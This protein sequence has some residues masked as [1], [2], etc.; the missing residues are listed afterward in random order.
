M[1]R[2]YTIKIHQ[3]SK[4]FKETRALSNINLEFE[5]GNIY[6]IVGRNGS[7]KTVLLKCI[8]GLLYP[9][10]G[11]VSINHKIIGKDV[12][13]YD[14]IGFIIE[15]P[16]FLYQYSGYKNLKML[17]GLKKKVTKDTIKNW[18]N[19]VG[20]NPD[21]RKPVAKYSMGM[22]QR[23]GWAQVLM[24]EPGIIVLDEPFNGLDENG[25]E[26]FR[27]LL[28]NLKKEGRLILLCSHSREDIQLLCD[29]IIRLDQG[30]IVEIIH[31]ENKGKL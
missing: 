23:L 1:E 31:S 13:F 24:E 30:E 11:Y 3:L 26:M 20:L 18:M 15:N 10:D 2:T 27:K 29:M 5:G 9:N 6:G 19:K 14:G 21:N 28:M 12:D 16:G 7:G 25:V 22:K 17:A 4:Q 8:C